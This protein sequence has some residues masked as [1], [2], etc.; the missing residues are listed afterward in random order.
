MASVAGRV[1]DWLEALVRLRLMAGREVECLVDTGASVALV[2]PASLVDELGLPIIGY[3]DEL[4]MVGGETT[5]AVLALAQIEWLSEVRSVEV[6]IRDD[7][8]IGTELLEDVRLVIDYP[9]R[10]LTISR[11]ENG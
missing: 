10:T 6:I 5:S 8:I 1:T 7:F 11:E 3:E 2:L 4:G 9:Q